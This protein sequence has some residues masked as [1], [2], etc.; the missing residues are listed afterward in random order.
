MRWPMILTRAIFIPGWWNCPKPESYLKSAEISCRFKP[1]K[2]RAFLSRN[3]DGEVSCPW[4]AACSTKSSRRGMERARL[5][6]TRWRFTTMELCSTGRSLIPRF[7]EMNPQSSMSTG[8]IKGWTEALQLMKTGGKWK[9]FIPFRSR[10][11]RKA[12]AIRSA[13]TK[14]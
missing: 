14:P 9:V 10:L 2:R 12:E 1:G 5:Q 11:C 4:K 3:K 7:N 13:R 6:T 8:V